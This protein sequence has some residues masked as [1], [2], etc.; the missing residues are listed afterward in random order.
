MDSDVYQPG[1]TATHRRGAISDPSS[2]FRSSHNTRSPHLPKDHSLRAISRPTASGSLLPSS[3]QQTLR[4]VSHP[5]PTSFS[6]TLPDPSSSSPP[7]PRIKPRAHSLPPEFER[8][9]EQR[10]RAYTSSANLSNDVTMTPTTPTTPSHTLPA[11]SSDSPATT[12]KGKA[13]DL[14]DVSLEKNPAVANRPNP[15]PSPAL[16]SPSPSS[17]SSAAGSDDDSTPN[18]ASCH[19][20]H[21]HS[22]RHGH[23]HS[24]HRQSLPTSAFPMH[25]RHPL[26]ANAHLAP[27]ASSSSATSSVH[28]I[29]SP[30]IPPHYPLITRETLKELELE[31]TLRSPQLRHDL[32]FDPGLQFRPTSGRRKREQT[33]RYWEAV[34]REMEWG[35][36][37]TSFDRD[38]RIYP[39]VCGKTGKGAYSPFRSTDVPV[40]PAWHPLLLS[41]K[42]RI[43]PLLETLKEVLHLVIH[44]SST[45]SPSNANNAQTGAS[46]PTTQSSPS[47]NPTPILPAVPQPSSAHADPLLSSFDPALIQQ[48]IQHGVF[49]YRSVFAWI[50]DVMKMHCA[51]M[52]DAMVESMVKMVTDPEESKDA[53]AARK[54]VKALRM[55]F[56]ILEVMKLDIANHQLQALRP[57][58]LETSP[59][60]ELKTF[61]ERFEKGVTSLNIT[62]RWISRAA[63]SIPLPSPPSRPKLIMSALCKAMVDLVFDPPAPATGASAPSFEPV[64]A[65]FVKSSTGC[66]MGYP[67]TLYLDHARLNSYVNDAAD[68]LGLYML[69]M[70]FRQLTTVSASS[71]VEDWEI[72]RVK[73]EVWEVGPSRLGLCF[74]VCPSTSG[75]PKGKWEKGMGDVVLQVARRVEEVRERVRRGRKVVTEGEDETSRRPPSA[76]LLALIENWQRTNYTK[77]SPLQKIMKERLRTA[78]LDVV[79][80]HALEGAL[81]TSV[82]GR[83]GMSMRKVNRHAA[84]GTSSTAG[85][86]RGGG[87]EPLMPEIVHLGERIARLVVF[88]AKVYRRLYEVEEFVDTEL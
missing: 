39:C 88:H 29:S 54:P 25:P 8:F 66:D 65:R 7:P 34:S 4:P 84:A 59:E 56:E 49:D 1:R 6:P 86:K 15:D 33:E 61:Q 5:S 36:T 78:V 81:K 58:L 44:P 27:W 22:H 41:T 60:F 14:A 76:D 42:P 16:V 71:G 52:R 55:C 3:R 85:Q 63:A 75:D 28:V 77:E 23:R 45:I 47:G 79:K 13:K 24:Y 32:L 40:H 38:G 48:E 19:R 2:S 70:L 37:C 64:Q 67:E 68:L 12:T 51:P 50:G 62:R 43:L 69:I 30:V 80:E 73:R 17:P 82:V 46:S 87:L 9:A 11:L 74:D 10:A 20:R 18:S 21:H 83:S 57:Y 53:D 72:D 26:S 35:C 31:V